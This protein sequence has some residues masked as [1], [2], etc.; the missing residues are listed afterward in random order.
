METNIQEKFKTELSYRSKRDDY[1]KLE[2]RGG[3][4]ALEINKGK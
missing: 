1:H 2:G 3:P 4:S